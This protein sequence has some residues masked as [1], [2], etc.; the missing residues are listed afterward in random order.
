MR[1]WE[2]IGLAASVVTLLAA[3][4]QFLDAP[5]EPTVRRLE[6][7][8]FTRYRLS[9]RE[10]FSIEA[11]TFEVEE[12][13]EPGVGLGDELKRRAPENDD[14]SQR[15]LSRRPPRNQRTLTTSTVNRDSSSQASKLLLLASVIL[16][17]A[18][19]LRLTPC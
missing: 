4:C 10:G 15:L 13:R 17:A 11:G 18:P 19:F 5:P 14:P 3:G 12:V 2:R 1:W 6:T 16:R 7:G 9:P 8:S